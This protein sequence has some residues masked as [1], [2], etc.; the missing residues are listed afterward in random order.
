M[1][2]QADA[3]ELVAK[4]P[5]VLRLVDDH[6]DVLVSAAEGTPTDPARVFVDGSIVET[7]HSGTTHTTRAYPRTNSSWLVD[8]AAITAYRLGRTDPGSAASDL[9]PSPASQASN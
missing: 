2:F 9:R 8:G 3:F 5:V 7:F 1:T 4:G 6:S